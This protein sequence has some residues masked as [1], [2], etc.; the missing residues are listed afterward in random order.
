MMMIFTK[1]A[2]LN[3]SI[4]KKQVE[5]CPPATQDI[6]LN[7][8]NRQNAIDN[9]GY[10]PLNPAE[11]NKDFWD[12]K[13]ERWKITPAQAKTAVCGNCIFFI[14][15]PRMLNCIAEGIG[16]EG[17]DAMGTIDAGEVGYCNAIDFKCAAERTC[18]AWAAGG[19]V[20]E[21]KNVATPVS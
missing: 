13:A 3:N 15:T 6:Q 10:G 14:R 5:G 11:P 19:P 8:K 17:E 20:T 1:N 4:V 18:N 2:K 12:D 16:I 7:L 21:E 9:V